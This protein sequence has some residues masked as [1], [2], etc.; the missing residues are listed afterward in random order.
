MKGQDTLDHVQ[1][2]KIKEYYSIHSKIYDLTRWT[3]LFGRKAL[4][5]QLP[6][7]INDTF[8]LLEVGCGTGHIIYKLHNLYPQATLFG[9]D[10][11]SHMLALAN[12]K[13]KDEKVRFLE[14]PYGKQTL[15]NEDFDVILFSYSLSM[16]NPDWKKM[17]EHAYDDLKPGGIIAVTDFHTT[18]I[19]SFENWMDMNHVR[20]DGHLLR[21]L[22]GKFDCQKIE[23]KS[24]YLGLWKYF[25]FIGMK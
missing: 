10:V 17:L 24:T 1:V 12:D 22:T 20:M 18:P 21:W 9:L 7:S 23:I 8:K 25:M 6:F 15:R 19:R 3:F 11:S 16:I 2:R 13:V 4:C 5:K 14:Q